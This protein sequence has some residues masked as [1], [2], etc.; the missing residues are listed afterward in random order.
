MLPAQRGDASVVYQWPRDPASRHQGTQ[1]LPMVRGLREEYEARRF[2]PDIDL[3]ERAA[4]GRRILKNS[5]ICNDRQEFVRARP[6]YCPSR[7]TFS[8][9]RYGRLRNFM[10]WQIR[11]MSVN[12]NIGIDGDH[13]P[14]PS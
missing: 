7:M 1:L 9:S 2:E 6:R 10:K 3:I 5:A 8:Q 13:V 4:W 14:R 11:A 12:K